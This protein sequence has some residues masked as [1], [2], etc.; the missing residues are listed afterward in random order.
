MVQKLTDAPTPTHTNRPAESNMPFQLF[1]SWGH[2]NHCCVPPQPAIFSFLGPFCLYQANPQYF[3]ALPWAWQNICQ[4]P[5]HFLDYSSPS[6]GG[7]GGGCGYKGLLYGQQRASKVCL[8]FSG[9]K[10]FV[11]NYML[12]E[13]IV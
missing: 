13:T 1:Q 10:G 9:N 4:R 8:T 3:P 5:A 12:F 11:R 6:L 7:S 2:K